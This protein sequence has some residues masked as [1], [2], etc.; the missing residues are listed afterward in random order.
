M[1]LTGPESAN[2]IKLHHDG[3]QGDN[4]HIHTKKVNDTATFETD[5]ITVSGYTG[6][7]L[8][9]YVD[10]LENL[11]NNDTIE[12]GYDMDGLGYTVIETTTG[13]GDFTVN[14]NKVEDVTIDSDIIAIG[15]S[16]VIYIK[17]THF[18]YL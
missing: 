2:E 16:I 5:P 13:Y 15:D 3:G 18:L 9:I 11:D 17:I 7:N 10:K 4:G 8:K 12:L 6:L 14:G 1:S